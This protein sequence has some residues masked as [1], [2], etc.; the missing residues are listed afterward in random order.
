MPTTSNWP[1]GDPKNVAVFTTKQ[2]VRERKPILLVT[3]DADDG[4]W[5]FHSGETVHN[6][7]VMLIALSEAVEI[8]QTIL[9]LADLPFGWKAFRNSP[10]D[11]WKRQK[12]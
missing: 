7:D 3:H 8:D 2:I 11:S 9:Q 5:Q 6:G 12:A 1:F 4:A 10:A